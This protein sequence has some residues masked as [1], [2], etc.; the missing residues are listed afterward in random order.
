MS[1]ETITHDS[2]TRLVEAGA[3]RAA[4]VV[5][6]PGG[7]GVIF[8]YGTLERPLAAQ[9]GNVRVFR[10][11]EAIVA[12][13]RDMGI[14]HFEVDAADYDPHAPASA[15]SES[16]AERARAQM[17]AAHEA[18]AYDKWF[19]AEITAAIAEADDPATQKVA[20]EVVA[21]ALQAGDAAALRALAGRATSKPAAKTR[22]K[23]RA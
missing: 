18:A 19:R 6:Q 11:F 10:R 1:T 13:L 15:R 9:R 17:K 4:Q 20:H 16:N 14:V 22:R 7:W 2:V 23:A 21:E 5:G 12:Y 3:I 8:K